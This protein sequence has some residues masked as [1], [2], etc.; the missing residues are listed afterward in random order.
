MQISLRSHL[1]AGTTAAVA[2]TLVIAP[3]NVALQG[4][5]ALPALTASA[6]AEVTLAAFNS[7]LGQLI[8]TGEL[9]QNYIFG[10]FYNGGDSPTPGAGEANWPYAGFDQTGGLVLNYLLYNEDQLG[11]YSAVGIIP[12][13]IND[14]EPVQRQ[15]QANWSNYVNVALTQAT[16]AAGAIDTGIWTFPQA[17]VSAAEL[18]LSG[19]IPGAIQVLGQAVVTPIAQATEAVF[20]AVGYIVSSVIAKLAAVVGTIPPIV[21]TFVGYAVRGLS[22]L[23]EQAVGIGTTVINDVTSGNFEGAWNTAV[24]GLLGPSGLPGSVTPAPRRPR[25]RASGA[26]RQARGRAGRTGTPGAGR[27]ASGTPPRL[28]RPRSRSAQRTLEIRQI[29]GHVDGVLLECLERDHIEGALV[30]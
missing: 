7:P 27:R 1:A 9:L 26:R 15:L 10:V 28:P 6:A 17:L 24:D 21:T 13:R 5:P 11:N 23:A 20:D 25:R 4:L 3:G 12:Q 29:I 2:A 8:G 19:D 14:A 16:I 22:L 18:A 30:G